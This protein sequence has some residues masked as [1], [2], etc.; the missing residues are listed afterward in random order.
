MTN[1]FCG[2]VIYMAPEVFRHCYSQAA[3]VFSFG[4]MLWELL[5]CVR[6]TSGMHSD[7]QSKF[8]QPLAV[9]GKLLESND[10][11]P[12]LPL[13]GSPVHVDEE[14]VRLIKD[15]WRSDPTDRPTFELIAQFLG[16]YNRRAISEVQN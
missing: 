11:R 6:C 3:D 4:L 16:A 5:Y 8:S 1:T 12:Q 14:I 15:A 13:P 10:N 9:I 7:L 2:T